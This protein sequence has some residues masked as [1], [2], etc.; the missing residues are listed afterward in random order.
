MLQ[1]LGFN[2]EQFLSIERK[3]ENNENKIYSYLISFRKIEMSLVSIEYEIVNTYFFSK[4]ILRY[5]SRAPLCFSSSACIFASQN[6]SS[7]L[8]SSSCFSNSFF[9]A[10]NAT[11]VNSYSLSSYQIKFQLIILDPI[12]QIVL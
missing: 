10:S 2:F 5:F 1:N 11:I 7:L 8:R 9:F 4:A 3:I 12:L 6:V